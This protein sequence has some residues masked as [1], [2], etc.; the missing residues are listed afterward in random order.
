MVEGPGEVGGGVDLVGVDEDEVE[1]AAAFGGEEG[2]GLEGGADAEVDHVGEAGRFDVLP[3]DLGAVGVELERG[4][5]AIGGQ[6]A[7]HRDGRVAAEGP[8]LEDPAGVDRA[9]RISRSRPWG[10]E[11]WISGMPAAV[12]AAR[13]PSSAWSTSAKS[14]AST[15][16]STAL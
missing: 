8:E 1:V 12:V 11:T 16:A 5:Q 14:V 15:K 2:E 13:A 4:Q 9:E 6:G 10:A 7:G 3:G